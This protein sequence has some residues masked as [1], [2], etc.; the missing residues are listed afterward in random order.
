MREIIEKF[1]P[2]FAHWH[3]EEKKILN[4]HLAFKNLK[5]LADGSVVLNSGKDYFRIGHGDKVENDSEYSLGQLE[6]L[7]PNVEIYKIFRSITVTEVNSDGKVYMCGNDLA[8]NRPT[9]VCFENGEKLWQVY[10]VGAAYDIN[11]TKSYIVCEFRQPKK[12]EI[13]LYDIA[14]G[15]YLF[16]RD[17]NLVLRE[18]AFSS[19]RDFVAIDVVD[20]I[21][22]IDLVIENEPV[23]G[24]TI[25]KVFMGPDGD[26]AACLRRRGAKTTIC[27]TD[28]ETATKRE[29]NFNGIGNFYGNGVSIGQVDVRPLDK[30]RVLL[31]GKTRNGFSL[32]V[33]DFEKD[34]FVWSNH[35]TGKLE[36]IDIAD[37]QISFSY[38][39]LNQNNDPIEHIFETWKPDRFGGKND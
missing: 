16:S 23:Q 13:N 18:A 10:M 32:K 34:R 30:D 5:I 1:P 11:L 14:N 24:A 28:L 26:L 22:A 12:T 2:D 17:S 31:S 27:L 15:G 7:V 9:L 38:H 39:I 20:E 25:D 6:T 29:A 33:F 21:K 3:C 36:A 4:R 37:R 19:K 35:Y 8:D